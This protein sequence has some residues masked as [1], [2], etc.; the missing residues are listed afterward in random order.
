MFRNNSANAARVS[1]RQIVD[2]LCALSAK[3]VGWS[4]MESTAQQLYSC[5]P[6]AMRCGLNTVRE[7]A[8]TRSGSE[9]SLGEQNILLTSIRLHYAMEK[10]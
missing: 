2:G 10:T 9:P 3:I 8:N 4:E 1:T 6:A 5:A 7:A